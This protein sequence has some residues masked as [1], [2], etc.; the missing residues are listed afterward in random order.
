MIVRYCIAYAL[1]VFSCMMPLQLN[2]MYPAGARQ[3]TRY[4]AICLEHHPL[5]DFIWLDCG[6]NEYCREQLQEMVNGA[7][8]DQNSTTLLCPHEGCR[9]HF[10]QND[11]RR[12]FNYNWEQADTI[13]RIRARERILRDPNGREC[14][15]PNCRHV[16]IFQAPAHRMRCPECRAQYCSDCRMLHNVNITCAAARAN[17]AVHTGDDAAGWLANN[18]VK[19]CPQCQNGIEKNE[20][21]NHMTCVRCRHEFCWVCLGP[22]QGHT[23]YYRC[24]RPIAQPTQP[25]PQAPAI[26]MPP[27]TPTPTPIPVPVC[28]TPPP[29]P[30]PGG[31]KV[32]IAVLVCTAAVAGY[33]TCKAIIKKFTK[34]KSVDNV[35]QPIILTDDSWLLDE[36]TTGKDNS[37][38][39]PEVKPIMSE[40]QQ[41][42]SSQDDWL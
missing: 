2:G 22:W 11:I 10:T 21:C 28:T 29:P 32:A 38:V 26:V 1:C 8:N 20:G 31:R 5:D 9:A 25:Q 23:E 16:Y 12:I 17:I 14:T 19:Q 42:N 39:V 24:T 36:E 15:T 18:E 3:H 6:H 40:E 33:Y 35:E 37:S 34:K 7:I 30:P 41:E 13:D 4:C 27:S